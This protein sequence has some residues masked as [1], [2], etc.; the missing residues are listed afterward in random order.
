MIGEIFNAKDYSLKPKATIQQTGKTGFNTDAINQLKI[1][2]NKAVVLAPDTQDKKVL[3]MAVVE[4]GNCGRKIGFKV[5]S[6]QGKYNE[7]CKYA[8]HI[9]RKI[10]GNTA[11]NM[12]FHILALKFHRGDGAR[13]NHSAYFTSRHFEQN[14]NS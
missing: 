3:Y 11:L 13:V 5:K 9:H 2:E 10:S 7:G 4:A 1:D 8:H 14:Y 12:F 6:I